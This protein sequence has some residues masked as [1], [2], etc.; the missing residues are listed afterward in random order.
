MKQNHNGSWSHLVDAC[1]DGLQVKHHVLR[2]HRPTLLQD[3]TKKNTHAGV[4]ERNGKLD[5]NKDYPFWGGGGLSRV[6]RVL[7]TP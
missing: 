6:L 5:L 7:K 2:P 1:P 3:V 4:N